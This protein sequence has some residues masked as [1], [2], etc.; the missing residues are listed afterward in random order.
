MSI[1]IGKGKKKFDK[2]EDIKR[3]EG[4]IRKSQLIKKKAKS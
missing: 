2:R 3:K 4:K 1:G